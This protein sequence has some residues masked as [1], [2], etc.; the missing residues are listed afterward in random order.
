[1][2]KDLVGNKFSSIHCLRKIEIM[3][4]NKAKIFSLP[5]FIYSKYYLVILSPKI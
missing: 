4:V 5:E 1:M 3:E 2:E